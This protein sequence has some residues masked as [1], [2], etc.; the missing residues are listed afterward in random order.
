MR[1]IQVVSLAGPRSVL[2]AEV[3]EPTPGDGQVVIDVHAA[4]VT[5]PEVL[6]SRGMYQLKPPPPFLLGSEVA[7]V[8]RSAPADTGISP[9]DR[10]AALCWFGGFADVAVTNPD[11]VFPLPDGVEFATGA[12]LP[13]NYL[14]AHFALNRRARLAEGETVLVHG[15]A[16]GVGTA[17]IQYARALGATVIA[18]VSSDD[19]AA[20]ATAAGAQHTVHPDGFLSAVKELTGGRG[21]D[22]VVDPVGGDRFT[23]SLRSLAPEG[24][25]L[26]IGF[27][28]GEIPTVKVNRLLLNNTSVDGVAWGEF[29]LRR[30]GYLQEQWADLAPLVASGALAAPI[31]HRLRLAEAAEALALMDERRAVGKVVLTVVED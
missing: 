25:L 17:T 21:V 8:V 31:G 2:L 7:G 29:A 20:L 18:V 9:G 11:M 1:A 10:V 13:I 14:T 22:V 27:V 4:G 30:P 24:R 12:A 28:G 15:A 6:L 3:D 23:D 19:K 16:G 5:F 26:V